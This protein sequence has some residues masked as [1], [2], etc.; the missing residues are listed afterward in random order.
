MEN[1]K[2]YVVYQHT[3]KQNGKK[4][5]GITAQKLERRWRSG[6]GYEGSVKFYPAILKYGWDGFEHE[7]L[8]SGLDKESAEDMEKC[9]IRD[10]NLIDDRYGYNIQTGGQCFS[11]H[12]EESKAM[13]AEKHR[14]PSAESRQRMHDGCIR[15]YGSEAKM[16][17]RMVELNKMHRTKPVVCVESGEF[18]LGVRDAM[19]KTGIGHTSVRFACTGVYQT[20]GGLHWRYA[21]Q[22]EISDYENANGINIRLRS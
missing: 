3:N 4:Y 16:R 2:E 14:N 17:E 7:V 22:D 12:S 20:A 13:N 10:L 8:A 5:V 15:R 21:T 1:A 19:K 18:F 9:L 11:G 6:R